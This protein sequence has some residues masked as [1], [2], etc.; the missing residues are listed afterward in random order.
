MVFVRLYMAF[1]QST[2]KYIIYLILAVCIVI[3]FVLVQLH[4]RS[5]K[6]A[7]PKAVGGVLDLSEW[8]FET[9]GIISLDGEWEFYW[10][11]LLTKED[12]SNQ[13][14]L[15]VPDSI[16]HIPDVWN[17]Y[18][19]DGERLPGMGYA[20]YRLVVK[21]KPSS[22][23]LG[24]K[25]ANLSTAYRLM[26]NDKVAASNGKVGTDAESSRSEYRPQVITFENGDG[27]FEII[28][29]VSNYEYARGGVWYSLYLGADHD[30]SVLKE[31]S[32]RREMLIFGGIIMMMV[33]QLSV[34]VFLR[35]NVSILYY[36]FMMLIIAARIPVTGE[37]VI[38]DLV[39][40]IN[41]RWLV[42]IEYLTICWAPITWILFL[43]RFYPEEISKR[44]VKYSV[45]IGLIL[46]AIT[47]FTP[48]RVFTSLLVYYELFV[49]TLFIFAFIRV[50][51]A[52]KRNREGV[53]LI[54][55]A[56]VAFFAT[57]VN[58]AM[59]QWNLISSRSGGMFGFSA[60]VIIFLQA[61]VLAAQ[62]SNTYHEVS[63]MSEK[64]QSLDRLKDEFLANTS[65]ELKTPINGIINITSA[66]LEGANTN[67]NTIHQQNLKVVIS[68]ARRLLNLI[69]DILDVS[70][71]KNGEIKLHRRA[72]D[73]KS[74][75]ESSLYVIG[76]MK[77]DKNIAFVNEIP[78]DLPPVYVDLERLRQILYNLIGN[79]L[80]FTTEGTV[81]IG[82][83][84]QDEAVVVWVEDTGCG[85]PN[86][87]ITDIFKPFF[88]VDSSETRE[89]GGSGL[90]LSI[91]KTLVELHGGTIMVASE[92]SKGSRFTFTL[93]LVHESTKERYVDSSVSFRNQT[94]QISGLLNVSEDTQRKYAV[95]IADDDPASLT[96]L[97]NILYQEGY[98]VKA[99]TNGEDALS[100]IERQNRFDLVILDIMMPKMTGYEVLKRIRIKYQPMEIPVLL[101]TAKAR[102]EDLQAGFD[103][104]A[105]DY[106]AKP[107]ESVELRTRV[108][109]LIQ[110][111]ESV[112]KM[113]ASEL[114]FLQ[115][116][117][118]PHFLFNSL[119]VIA[120]LSTREPER[121]REL[122]YN[123]SDYLRGSFN[124]DNH[125]GVISLASELSTVKAYVAIE[126]ER[127]RDKLTM[128]YDIDES[129]EF[130][131]PI[132]TVQP[133]VE[134]AIRHGILKKPNGG[135]VKLTIKRL[136][137]GVLIMVED[138]G[139]GISKEL[140]P[141]LL[142]G[143]AEENGVGL[144]NIQR[145]LLIHYNTKL[146][147]QSY[148]GIGTVVKTIIPL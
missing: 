95:L 123:L 35:K 59:Y 145:R 67:L 65:H 20:T 56:T 129:L 32:S 10:H 13:Q 136:E 4:E 118:K 37:Y 115:A 71:I 58:D 107:F 51:M 96:A 60:F 26:I 77:G 144:R 120:A 79:A 46:T 40:D 33:Y 141:I 85:I 52:I 70:I 133:L 92:I 140:V 132:L 139:V 53:G 15:I 99:V 138:D 117:I 16:V 101:L 86:N 48:I 103:A 18:E 116:Q 143:T 94:P 2:K 63:E 119:S 41:I 49:I 121:A 45:T 55:L 108:R 54:T 148:E 147:I 22:D 109:T 128:Q 83:T 74:V 82:A 25:I 126:K 14:K 72:V 134:N 34:Y 131:I 69:N 47:F 75:A 62:F 73:L 27:N 5:L 87:Q 90:G 31:N 11:K 30:I 112:S 3:P 24:L 12:F 6:E 89:A 68:S 142:E 7:Q 1:K 135:T 50:V 29:Q 38:A 97:Y 110:L 28:L 111:K 44:V 137:T 43:N 122:L 84:V 88:Q 105:N 125:E 130:A 9:Q 64:L 127:F 146:E 81:I 104:G 61:Y 98:Y 91:T 106:I 23:E 102:P 39:S 66:V 100:E 21:G 57:F 93:P 17:N 42:I 78:G 124:F 36:I 19:V 114:S 76:Q 80:K 113:I 8:D